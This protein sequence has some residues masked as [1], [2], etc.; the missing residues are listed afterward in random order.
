MGGGRA[1]CR[2][3]WRA[4]SEWLRAA[5]AA[6]PTPA[7]RWRSWARRAEE[8]PPRWPR[9]P[10]AAASRGVVSSPDYELLDRRNRVFII[11]VSSVSGTVPGT[12][13]K[14]NFGTWPLLHQDLTLV[15]T[16]VEGYS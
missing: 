11:F 3:A 13:I 10:G 8:A 2:R 9:A 16:T 1:G 5:W 4:G 12:Q 15:I 6:R 7:A 14:V